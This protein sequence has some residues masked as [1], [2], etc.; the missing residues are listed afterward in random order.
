MASAELLLPEVVAQRIHLV[1]GC[2]VMLDEDLAQL[3]QVQTLALVQAVGRNLRR[4]P[5]EFMFRLT[6]EEWAALKSQNVI[7]KG[8]GGRGGRRYA[9]YA[10]T[11]HGALMLMGF[12][13]DLDRGHDK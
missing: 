12:T 5:T 9:P 4:F 1:R 6:D 11:E 3:C 7:S 8:Q 13:A 10:F 2:K